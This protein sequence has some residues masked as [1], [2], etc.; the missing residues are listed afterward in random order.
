MKLGPYGSLILTFIIH[1]VW[2][3]TPKSCAWLPWVVTQFLEF[4]F[5]PN[6]I[7]NFKFYLAE[8]RSEILFW[9]ELNW[10][11]NP[12]QSLFCP[13]PNI[14]ILSTYP[15]QKWMLSFYAETSSAPQPPD[16]WYVTIQGTGDGTR[17]LFQCI[18]DKDKGCFVTEFVT[19]NLFI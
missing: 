17:S 2:C 6:P 19:L 3:G 12:D 15:Y 9:I 10:K 16:K 4:Q 5:Y 8:S 14:F 7:V 1:T 18:W 11:S 13:I